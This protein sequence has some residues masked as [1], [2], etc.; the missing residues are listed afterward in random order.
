MSKQLVYVVSV[1]FD[2]DVDRDNIVALTMSKAGAVQIAQRQRDIGFRSLVR[3]TAMD[4][5]QLLTQI[6][7]CIAVG[8]CEIVEEVYV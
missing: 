4:G 5:H 6:K 8:S 1:W 2:A 7:D 3:E